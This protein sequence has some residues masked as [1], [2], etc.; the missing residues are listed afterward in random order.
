MSRNTGS[1]RSSAQEARRVRRYYAALP[2]RVRARVREL[3][4]IIRAAAPR[5]VEGISYGIPVM[6][7]DGRGVIAF[8]SWK[9]HTSIYPVTSGVRKAAERLGLE[10]SKGT[11]RFPLDRALPASLIRRLVRERIAAVRDG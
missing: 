3:R 8:A 2:P 10:T 5:G 7:V 9:E 4:R 6:R 11:V 1:D